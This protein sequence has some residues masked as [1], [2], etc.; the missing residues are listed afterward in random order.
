MLFRSANEARR[1]LLKKNGRRTAPPKKARP[2]TPPHSARKDPAGKTGACRRSTQPS[3]PR[4]HFIAAPRW[5]QQICGKVAKSRCRLAL[6]RSLYHSL[7]SRR[8]QTETVKA[9]TSTGRCAPH[10]KTENLHRTTNHQGT[11]PCSQ[12]TPLMAAC[13]SRSNN[14]PD[15][16]TNTP[17]AT[18]YARWFAENTN[19]PTHPPAKLEKR[20]KGIEPSS[21]AWKATALP[22]SYTRIVDPGR[23]PFATMVL[24]F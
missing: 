20:V 11:T 10:R 16:S 6:P 21:L 1:V 7:P 22:L 9:P 5:A 12:H 3:V 4:L 13:A 24:E 15:T 23:K 19:D 18:A 14:K 2:S 8:Q 17:T